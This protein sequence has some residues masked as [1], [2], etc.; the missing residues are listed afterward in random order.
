MR[1]DLISRLRGAAAIAGI[2]GQR[3]YWNKR[4]LG[5][6]VPAIVL[7]HVSPGRQYTFDG[8]S[9]LHGARI[10]F[11]C[12]GAE[13]RDFDPLFGAVLAEM[14]QA[15]VVGSTAFSMSFLDGQRDMPTVD[16]DGIGPVGGISADFFVWFENV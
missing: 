1:V 2:A 11:D 5:D 10:Q 6:P 15:K 16:V 8:A 7:Y 9:G 14:E 4:K 3:I 13:M 12:I